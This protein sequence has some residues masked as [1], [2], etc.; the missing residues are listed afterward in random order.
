MARAPK[1]LPTAR[2]VQ[3]L[4]Y[5]DGPQSVLLERSNDCKIVSVAIEKDG[6]KYPFF[7]AAISFD[8]WE[9]YRN[10]LLDIRFLFM[11]PRW[12]E[13]YIFDLDALVDGKL[14]LH[15]A[16]KDEFAESEYVPE[17]GFFSYDHSE[18]IKAPEVQGL[19]IKNYSTDGIWDLPDF[20]EFYSRI[21]DIYL[22]ILSLR[23]YVLPGTSIETK[24]TIK[25]AFAGPPLRG[26]S[27]YVNLYSGLVHAQSSDDRIHVQKIQY[28]SPGE[29]N[30]KGINEIF[31]EMSRYLEIFSE[32]YQLLKQ[33]YVRM[34]KFLSKSNL[35]RV[36]S[37]DFDN[38]NPM[39]KI[40]FLEA[41]RFACSLGLE[42]RELIYEL[43]GSNSLKFIKIL[44]AHFRRME[45]YFM[46]FA[47]GRIKWPEIHADN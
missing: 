38:E 33:E 27:S 14:V 12:K 43:S 6:Y 35:L 13:W 47:E 9:R 22:F 20:T 5:M 42:E 45:S 39:A 19:S 15:K 23:K 25:E 44:L 7:G 28:A 4:E 21:T 41:D 16:A 32:N 40:V 26:G 11:L 3:V 46:F 36:S 30:V 10:G 2:F 18:S 17:P 29:V 31:L 34:H 1:K 37:E 8:Q 24:M